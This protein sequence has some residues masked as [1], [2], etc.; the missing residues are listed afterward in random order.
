MQW[1]SFQALFSVWGA[2]VS[3]DWEVS[4]LAKLLLFK[5]CA[6]AFIAE[7]LLGFHGLL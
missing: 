6:L 1:F 4:R 5:F 3:W 2:V 7:L